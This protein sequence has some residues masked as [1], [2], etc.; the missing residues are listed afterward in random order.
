MT[1]KTAPAAS[2]TSLRSRVGYTLGSSDWSADASL[3]HLL[4][5]S[6]AGD[7]EVSVKFNDQHIPDSPYLVPVVAPVNDARRLSV[8]GLQVRHEDTPPHPAPP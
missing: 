1:A 7:Y 4:P 3:S 6:S 2:L 5:A 8:A